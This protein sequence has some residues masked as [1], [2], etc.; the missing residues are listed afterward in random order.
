MK[1]LKLILPLFLAFTTLSFS[2]ISES[3]KNALISLY[4]A[5][6]GENW[7]QKWNLT[8]SADNWHGVTVIND[9]VVELNLSSNNLTGKL[10]S[11][12]GDL[13]NLHVLNLSLNKIIGEIPTSI[14]KLFL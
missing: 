5:T 1:T 11:N 2:A 3:E 7:N 4:N 10:P 13:S 9:Q 8:Q 12:L 14:C 6:D